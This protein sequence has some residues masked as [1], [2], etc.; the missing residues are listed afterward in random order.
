MERHVL[1]DQTGFLSGQNLSL[2]GQMTCL[3]T[4]I[5]CGLAYVSRMLQVS[6]KLIGHFCRDAAK[7]WAIRIGVEFVSGLLIGQF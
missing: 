7:L 6:L 1:S 5:I 2:A 3:L 4:K